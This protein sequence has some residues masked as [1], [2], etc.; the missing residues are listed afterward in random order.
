[1]SQDIKKEM[2]DFPGL[3]DNEYIAYPSLWDTKKS[4]LRENIIAVSAYI[5]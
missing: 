3:N 2:Q 1:M 4:V 5:N